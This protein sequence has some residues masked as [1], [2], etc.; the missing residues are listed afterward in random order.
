MAELEQLIR[1]GDGLVRNW[2]E[3]PQPR[4]VANTRVEFA[5]QLRYRRIAARAGVSLQR[6][7]LTTDIIYTPSGTPTGERYQVLGIVH[8]MTGM[9]SARRE[10]I[11]FVDPPIDA[12]YPPIPPTVYQEFFD[13]AG[14][15][16]RPIFAKD[17]GASPTSDMHNR[18]AVLAVANRDAVHYQIQYTGE[19]LEAVHFFDRMGRTSYLRK[20][21]EKGPDL[22]VWEMYPGSASWIEEMAREA[23]PGK[24][25]DWLEK[26]KD[27][28]N[29]I[30]PIEGDTVL[31]R[32]GRVST[33]LSLD[34]LAGR[35]IKASGIEN[36]LQGMASEPRKTSGK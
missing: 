7:N 28:K 18:V 6:D 16:I 2:A 21:Q 27:S 1:L 31:V 32:G 29:K 12:A 13:G 4:T 36:V 23:H 15:P 34:S 5:S 25:Q 33:S 9:Y 3:N 14:E 26:T 22:L 24:Y 19:E 35:I 8:Q 11:L 20:P 30:V 17:Y 10:E